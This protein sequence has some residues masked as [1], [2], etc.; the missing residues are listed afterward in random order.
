MSTK[1]SRSHP[2]APNFSVRHVLEPISNEDL[3][4]GYFLALGAAGR[5]DKTLVTYQESLGLLRD[6]ARREGLP[7]P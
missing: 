6:F 1:S 7:P 2:S 4:R 5:K 3:L